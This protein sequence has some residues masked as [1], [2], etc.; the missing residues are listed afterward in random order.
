MPALSNGTRLGSEATSH[1]VGEAFSPVLLLLL[2]VTAAA[3]TFIYRSVSPY[4]P[5]Y[6]SVGFAFTGP[7]EP[8]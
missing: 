7:I 2:P 4:Y 5:N 6:S 8:A 1:D 3:L